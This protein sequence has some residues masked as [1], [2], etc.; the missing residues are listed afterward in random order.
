MFGFQFESRDYGAA[1]IVFF[2]LVA[3]TTGERRIDSRHPGLH[4]SKQVPRAIDDFGKVN[5][6]GGVEGPKFL[7]ILRFECAVPF[8]RVFGHFDFK[9]SLTAM[10]R[11]MEAGLVQEEDRIGSLHDKLMVVFGDLIPLAADLVLVNICTFTVEGR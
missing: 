2:V 11:D 8:L 7:W 10:I 4:V 5:G 9:N 3:T 1:V 6:I